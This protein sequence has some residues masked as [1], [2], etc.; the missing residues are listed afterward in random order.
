MRELLENADTLEKLDSML[1]DID[2]K[3]TE[4]DGSTDKLVAANERLL[5]EN[6]LQGAVLYSIVKHFGEKG[7]LKIPNAADDELPDRML[8]GC[9]AVGDDLIITILEGD[10]LDQI[11]VQ[12]GEDENTPND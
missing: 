7:N 5:R 4:L 8:L 11:E 9:N 2:N 10:A 3:I 12:R 6:A 1:E